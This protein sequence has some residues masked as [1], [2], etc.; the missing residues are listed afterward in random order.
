[1]CQA[2]ADIEAKESAV[3]ATME[4][5]SKT[6]KAKK[7]DAEQS[8]EDRA[9]NVEKYKQAQELVLKGKLLS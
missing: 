6:I 9:K 2:K 7:L 5:S 8:Q 3:K 1:M 4:Q